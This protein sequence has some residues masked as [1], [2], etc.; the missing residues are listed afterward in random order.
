MAETNDK[1]I[2][3]KRIKNVNSVQDKRVIIVYP[4]QICQY[5]L[6]NVI[7]TQ[8]KRTIVVYLI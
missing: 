6:L 5:K 1:F 7:L 2:R 3:G 4:I 8:D